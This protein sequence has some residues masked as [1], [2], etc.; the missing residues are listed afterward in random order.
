MFFEF[1]FR[2]AGGEMRAVDRN[3]E[4]L[5]QIRQSAQM[6]F[7]AVREDDGRDVVF[8]LVEKTKIRDRN[9]DAV[10]GLLRGSPSRRRESTSRRRNAQPCNSFQTR[11]YRREG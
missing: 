4:F 11:R 2:Q 10:R 8:V 3:I 6:I 7:V 1:A 5:E 9:V